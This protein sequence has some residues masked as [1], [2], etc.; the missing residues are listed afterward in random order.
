MKI[1]VMGYSGAGKSTLAQKL[2]AHYG[3]AVLHL[4]TVQFLPGWAL[5]DRAEAV[6]IVETFMDTQ[7]GWIIDGN[8]RGFLQER[9]LE[10]ADRILYLDF[11]RRV[12]LKQAWKRYRSNRGKTRPD[13]ADGCIEKMDAEFVKWILWNGR[14]RDRRKAH[15]DSLNQYRDKAV[16]LKSGKAVTAYLEQIGI[17]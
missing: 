2:G 6:K 8:Y 5:R 9:R 16:V 7:D 11:P 13:M 12:C 3:C 15:Q 1:A 10:E 4:D 17:E 14:T